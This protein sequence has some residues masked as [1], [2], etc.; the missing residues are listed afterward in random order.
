MLQY[1]LKNN[2]NKHSLYKSSIFN[3][4]LQKANFKQRNIQIIPTQHK[5]YLEDFSVFTNCQRKFNQKFNQKFAQKDQFTQK[6]LNIDYF[7]IK[8]NIGRL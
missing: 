3:Q 4:I 1:F 8:S 5:N 6:I 7:S 2:K